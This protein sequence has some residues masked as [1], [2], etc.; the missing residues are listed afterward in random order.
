MKKVNVVFSLL[1]LVLGALTAIAPYSFAHVCEAGEKI[2]KCHWTGRIEL[3]LGISVAVL[4]LL[5]LISADAKYQLGLNAGILL[6]AL[7]VILTP[8]LLIGVCGMKSMHCASVSKPTLIVFGILILVI[9]LIQS[10]IEWKK[11]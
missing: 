6:N 7:G 1:I 10:L 9:T 4:G 11:K 3:F 2:M 5:K 8:T